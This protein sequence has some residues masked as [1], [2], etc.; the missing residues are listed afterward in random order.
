MS[1]GQRG[2]LRQQIMA[3]DAAAPEVTREAPP[4]GRPQ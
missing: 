2:N 4:S 3:S 1:L